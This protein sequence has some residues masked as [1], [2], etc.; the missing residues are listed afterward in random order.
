ML[1]VFSSG[2]ALKTDWRFLIL[3]YTWA[4]LLVIA[5]AT[6]RSWLPSDPVAGVLIFTF[7]LCGSAIILPCFAFAAVGWAVWSFRGRAPADRRPAWL[8]LAAA[9]VTFT[10]TTGYL[11]LLV[12]IIRPFHI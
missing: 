9:S 10:L 1:A 4:I 3:I 5:I 6:A 12:G 11:L 2:Y 8:A 7:G